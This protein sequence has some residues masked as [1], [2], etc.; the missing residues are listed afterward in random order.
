MSFTGNFMDAD[1]ALTFGLV[2]HVVPH[3]EL[4]PFTYRLAA[5]IIGNEQT[6]VRVL[7]GTYAQTTAD[8]D[9]WETEAR[10][11]RAWR[12]EHFS[13]ETVAARREAIQARGRTQ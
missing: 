2:N 8:D 5:D 10:T 12:R 9:A 13:P 7:R 4:L 6:A 1:E 11:S 3:A